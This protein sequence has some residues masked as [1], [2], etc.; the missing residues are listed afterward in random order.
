VLDADQRRPAEQ[1]IEPVRSDHVEPVERA[2][3]RLGVA[4]Q[5]ERV[6]ADRDGAGVGLGLRAE[7]LAQERLRAAGVDEEQ[8][9]R[10]GRRDDLDVELGRI[11]RSRWHGERQHVQRLRTGH[12]V[13]VDG[14]GVGRGASTAAACGGKPRDRHARTHGC[15]AI[16]V[17]RRYGSS[18]TVTR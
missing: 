10:R 13:G 1:A 6:A 15:D 9:P 3:L 4:R 5:R 8:A 18:A 11:Q 17:S 14:R 16:T 7:V 2:E 12:A